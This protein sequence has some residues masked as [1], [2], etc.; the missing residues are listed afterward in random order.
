MVEDSNG[1]LWLVSQTLQR[2]DPATGRFTAYRLDPFGTGR[3][4]PRKFP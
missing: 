4:G 2:F 1:V 3:A